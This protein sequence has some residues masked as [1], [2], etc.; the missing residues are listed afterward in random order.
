MLGYTMDTS[1]DT[2][3][4]LL[5]RANKL[6]AQ[7]NGANTE[8]LVR[9]EELKLHAASLLKA[10]ST[11]NSIYEIHAGSSAHT[12]GYV[13]CSE[14]EDPITLFAAGVCTDASELKATTRKLSA[15]VVAS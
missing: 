10:L 15:W 8:C 7:T 13:L 5:N 12:L 6:L 14:T 9:A 3:K 2:I 1:I 4:E 11:V